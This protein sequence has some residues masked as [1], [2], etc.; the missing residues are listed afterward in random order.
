MSASGGK[1]SSGQGLPGIAITIQA[2][3]PMKTSQA[4]L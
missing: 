3:E 1:M 4:K 2:S